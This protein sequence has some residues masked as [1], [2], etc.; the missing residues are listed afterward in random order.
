MRRF[1]TLFRNIRINFYLHFSITLNQFCVSCANRKLET[2]II[3]LTM[4]I[5]KICGENYISIVLL[6]MIA[7]YAICIYATYPSEWSSFF[8]HRKANLHEVLSHSLHIAIFIEHRLQMHILIFS[9]FLRYF[10]EMVV[11]FFFNL[12]I[13]FNGWIKIQNPRKVLR[14]I[15]SSPF[16]SNLGFKGEFAK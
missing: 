13:F 10:V 6:C 14:N 1:T 2:Y 16:P 12:E 9:V 7:V 15:Y 3:T 11:G 5:R 8:F 4:N